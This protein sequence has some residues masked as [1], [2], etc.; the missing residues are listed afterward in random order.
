M[1]SLSLSKVRDYF[2]FLGLNPTYDNFIFFVKKELA[3]YMGS[4]FLEEDYYRE[5]Y[6]DCWI[7]QHNLKQLPRGH[8]KTEMVGIWFTIYLAVCQP[9]NPFFEK[10][11]KHI[12]EQLLLAGDGAAMNAWG[13]RLKHFFY[14]NPKL[15]V[16]VPDGLKKE[17]KSNDLWNTKVMYLRN[18]HKIILRAI[19]DKAVRGNHV[20]RLHAD[21][22]V[23]ENS[24]VVDDKIIAK[25]NGAVDGTTTNKMA[26]VQVT[27]T[28]LRQ[29]DILFHL[30]DRGYN[31]KRFPAIINFEEKKILSPNRWS[32]QKL[33][34]TKKRIGSTRFQCEYML[35][36]IDDK[37]AL[38]K[39]Q[40]IENCRS[41]KFKITRTRPDWAEAVYLGVDFAF[42]DRLT[43]D[44]SAFWIYAELHVQGQKYLILLDYITKKGLS[45]MQQME[46][47][48][49]LHE[50]YQFDLMGLEENSIKAITREIKKDFGHLPIKRFW[51]GTHDQKEE[52]EDPS[53][54]YTTVGKRNLIIRMGT[55]FENRQII[56]P[57]G[58]EESRNKVDTF[59]TEC[60]S[61]A[62]EGGKLVEIGVHPDIPIAAAYA[63]E[64]AQRWGGGF[65]I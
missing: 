33:M 2:Q 48:E 3:P 39:R 30:K 58:D 32:F 29:T 31:F 20:D 26:M 17:G 57:D 4:H 34:E 1:E 16:F 43:A 47:I 55:Q 35:D 45:G 53:K 18:G 12:T 27:G 19:G 5:V 50:S 23:T 10:Y 49:E 9:V 21:D 24:T 25:W 38:I 28:P 62:Q 41:D 37:A 60:I 46:Y 56:L 64:V 13:E 22:L 51:T 11:E 36:P 8:S 6:E 59:I 65:M 61:F 15:R 40:W 52:T 42:S 7:A 63:G 44:K 54:E 14:E